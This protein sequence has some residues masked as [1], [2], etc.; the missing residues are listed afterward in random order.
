MVE[1]VPEFTL[2]QLIAGRKRAKQAGHSDLVA[3]FDRRIA[4]LQETETENTMAA[5]L[6]ERRSL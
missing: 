6:P 2:A 5:P 4:E 3:E 1:R